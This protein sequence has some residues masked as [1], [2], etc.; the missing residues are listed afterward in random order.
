MVQP[1]TNRKTTVIN[2]ESIE[3]D[4]HGYNYI[5]IAYNVCLDCKYYLDFNIYITLMIYANR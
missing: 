4:R 1:V 2:Q 3:G 5:L